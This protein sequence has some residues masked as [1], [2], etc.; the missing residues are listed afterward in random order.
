VQAGTTVMLGFLVFAAAVSAGPSAYD[1]GSLTCVAGGAHFQMW[2]GAKAAPTRTL[3]AEVKAGEMLSVDASAWT[4]TA[5]PVEAGK[6]AADSFTL[7]IVEHGAG[8]TRR[9]KSDFKCT[10]A[11][12]GKRTSFKPLVA[13]R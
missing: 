4:A 8:W 9:M 5:A 12:V 2:Q 3:G 7:Q 10:A 13:S 1:G 11:D 6:A